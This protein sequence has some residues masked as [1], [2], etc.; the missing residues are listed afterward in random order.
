M[1][2][3][4]PESKQ[5]IQEYGISGRIGEIT[6]A[7]S[8]IIDLSITNQCTDSNEFRLGGVYIGQMDATFVNVDID[9]NEWIGQEIVLSITIGSHTIPIGKYTIDSVSHTKGLAQVTAYDNMTKFDI[10]CN[11]SSGASASAYDFL[12]FACQE[13]HLSLGMTR[14]EVE[15]LPNGTQP[16]VLWEMCDIET[17]RDFIYWLS[18]SLGSFATMNRN[19]DLILKPFHKTVD[20]IIDYD[21]RYVD[22]SYG[23]HIVAY[24]SVSVYINQEKEYWGKGV[25]PHNP[26]L[27]PGTLN[28]GVNP[29]FQTT[30]ATVETCLENLANALNDGVEFVPCEV[31]VPFAFQYDLGDV[32]QFRYGQGSETNLFCVMGFTYNYYGECVLNGIPYQKNSKSKSEKSI[33]NVTT[34]S[35]KNNVNSYELKN[36]NPITIA[37]NT[38]ER[39]LRARIVSSKDTK[40][41]IQIEIDLET[42][43]NVTSK[44]YT[45]P[46]DLTDIFEDVSASTT[47]GI[48]TY[49]INSTDSLRYPEEI[50]LDGSHVLH[51]MYILPVSANTINVFEVYMKAERGEIF[52]D[53]GNAWLYASGSGL[54]GDT[55]WGGIIEISDV[56]SSFNLI[57]ATFTNA[58][59]VVSATPSTPTSKSISES[60]S[61]WNLSEITFA[62]ATDHAEV[63]TGASQSF[64]RVLEDGSIRITE[65]NDTRVTEGD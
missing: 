16:F 20:D 11:L 35:D 42:L 50:W 63:Q 23:D 17:M 38:T 62:N 12:A 2:S 32:L 7:E 25:I 57:E 15:A 5:N 64:R 6:I 29:F 53:R 65:N 55:N 34:S 59:E 45:S 19:G 56:A 36:Y 51:L 4:I 37:E 44:E 41:E 18:V 33:Q 10:P 24:N 58:T 28:I 22:S 26:S 48:V 21:V 31:L 8:N 1:Y 43:A 3:L 47:K 39:I 9:R 40:A 61:L 54:I 27:N 46:F 14:E 60:A 52:I 13:A 49:L 30:F